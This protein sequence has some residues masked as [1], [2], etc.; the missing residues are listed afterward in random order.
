MKKYAGNFSGKK[1]T[2]D[3]NN[4]DKINYLQQFRRNKK[5]QMQ[6]AFFFNI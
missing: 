2:L 1:K 3:D 4:Y 5:F 6:Q